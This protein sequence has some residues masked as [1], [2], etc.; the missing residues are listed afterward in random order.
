MLLPTATLVVE[1]DMHT[2]TLINK[3]SDPNI[4]PSKKEGEMGMLPCNFLREMRDAHVH[5]L[6]GME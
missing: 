5:L 2:F 6:N 3:N 4:P 1:M